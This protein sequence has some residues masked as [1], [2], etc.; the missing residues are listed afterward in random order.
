LGEKCDINFQNLHMGL[1]S[2]PTD[3]SGQQVGPLGSSVNQSGHHVWSSGGDHQAGVAS[4]GSEVDNSS[5]SFGEGGN[6]SQ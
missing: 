2:H 5:G 1:K 4:P 6:K 3:Q